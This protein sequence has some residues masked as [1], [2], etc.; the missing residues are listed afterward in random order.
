MGQQLEFDSY[1]SPDGEEYS[2]HD[3]KSGHPSGRWLMSVAGMG[4]PDID[5]IEQSGPY[6]HG[7]T[8]LDYRLRPRTLTYLHSRSA[9]SRDDYWDMRA[10]VI[11][12]L[13]PNR[14]A[15]NAMALGKLRKILPD[16]SK[17]DIDAL[18]IS[19]P[20]FSARDTKAWREWMMQEPIRFY[21]P[22]PTYYDPTPTAL[23]LSA[24]FCDDLIFSFDFPFVFCHEGEGYSDTVTYTG[25]W[26]TYPT[27]SIVGPVNDLVIRNVTTDET[28]SFTRHLGASDSLT[29]T[30]SYGNKT[31]VDNSGANWIGAL[32]TD[33]DL[34][35]W[36][37]APAPEA[38]G[39]VNQLLIS[40]YGTNANTAAWIS[41][42]TRYIGI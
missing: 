15:A 23:D 29:I 11:N 17:R 14:Q 5:Y 41:Y 7:S 4:M 2:F 34:A 22:D 26:S 35:T 9:R 33:S 30:L 20:V 37:I 32:S 24:S 10:D 25:T 3:Q 13:R 42:Y 16:G 31:I 28:L 36:H 39:G 27:F 8:I 12:Y 1:I 21:C 40:G 19:G 18:V 38:P 6:Q